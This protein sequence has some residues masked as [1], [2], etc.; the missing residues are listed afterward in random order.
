MARKAT[1]QVVERKRKGG[2]VFALRF[3][4]HGERQYVTL[5]RF[6][7]GWTRRKAEVELENVLA[8]VR[9]GIWQPPAPEPELGVE[10]KQEPD[11]H[12]FASDWVETWRHE[13]SERT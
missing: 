12:R 9:R 10:A 1:G 11:F 3:R 13:W 7:D 8:D 5:G 4:A 2:R 6:E